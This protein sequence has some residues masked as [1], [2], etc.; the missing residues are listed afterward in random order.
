MNWNALRVLLEGSGILRHHA[1]S[2]LKILKWLLVALIIVI[3]FRHQALPLIK[4]SAEKVY[5]EIGG[6]NAEGGR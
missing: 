3:L 1:K 6:T 5:L 2:G 4:I